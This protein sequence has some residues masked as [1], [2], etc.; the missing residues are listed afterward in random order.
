MPSLVSIFLQGLLLDALL[1]V[2]GEWLPLSALQAIV[3]ALVL[4]LGLVL[5]VL[6]AFLPRLPKRFLLPSFLFL[7]WAT[8]C[9]GFPLAFVIP[10]HAPA[11]L[12]GVQLLLAVALLLGYRRWRRVPPPL[13]LPRF[14]WANLAAIAA[15]TILIVPLALAAAAINA[16][17]LYLENSSGG[18]VKLRPDGLFLEER[19]MTRNNQHVRLVSMIHI[20]EKDFYDRIRASLPATGAAVVLLEGVTDNQGLLKSHFSYSK[21]AHLLGLTAQESSEFQ[22]HAKAA[23]ASTHSTSDRQAPL[24]YRRADVDIS[25]FQ[26]LTLAFINAVGVILSDPSAAT[27]LRTVQ[28]AHSPFQQPH[29]DEI[30]MR[31]I[32]EKRNEHLLGEIDRALETSQTVIVPWGALHLASIEASLKA[33]GFTETGRLTRPVIHFWTRKPAPPAL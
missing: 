19:E 8:V 4:S 3:T 17:G 28:D 14:S 33:R 7:L 1:R 22:R 32:L 12:A 15:A 16:T 29:V 11:I 6:A 23:S 10:S 27:I 13:E 2:F 30:V 5:Y 24:E 18:Y 9:G 25:I 26:P 31:D 21:I 20:G